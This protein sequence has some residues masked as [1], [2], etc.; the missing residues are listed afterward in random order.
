M[1]ALYCTYVNGQCDKLVTDDDHQFITLTDS[2]SKLTATETID[3]QLPK[4]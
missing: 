1:H 2:A 4:F 3:V